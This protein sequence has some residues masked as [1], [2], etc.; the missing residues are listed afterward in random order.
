M[1]DVVGLGGSAGSIEALKTF[2]S[3]M[4]EDSGLAFVVVLHLSPKY[5]SS[6]EV[7][8]QKWTSMPVI[9]VSE[10]IKVEANCVYVIPPRKHLLMNDG[11]LIL[12]VLPHEYGKRSAVDI[13][14]CTLAET[15]RSRSAAIV[16]SGVD[17]DGAIGIKRIKEVGGITVAQKPEEAQHDGMPRSAIES[18][19]VDWV[20]PVAEMPRRLLES[21]RRNSS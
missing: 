20:L 2:F 18:G 4:P 1:Q 19:M 11:H 12:A 13:F 16:L 6:L 7:V 3:Y 14:F 15:H 10:P 8:L 17:S 9:R 5:E 21:L